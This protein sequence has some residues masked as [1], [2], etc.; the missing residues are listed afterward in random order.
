[1]Q[2]ASRPA[3][4]Q[5]RF[6]R[7]SKVPATH[8]PRLL[9]PV[10]PDALHRGSADRR[11][12]RHDGLRQ[13]LPAP[14]QRICPVIPPDLRRLAPV[15]P[16]RRHARAQGRRGQEPQFVGPHAG[17]RRLLGRTDGHRGQLAQ[18]YMPCKTARRIAKQ[19]LSL[20]PH[21]HGL[22]DRH[23]A[24]QGVRA[25]QPLVQHRGLRG[26]HRHGRHPPAQQPPLDERHHGGCRHRHPRHGV[27][28]LPGRPD[29][30]GEG[31][32]RHRQLC[33]LRPVP[34]AVVPGLLARHFRRGG[35]LYPPIRACGR[36]C[37][38]D[39]P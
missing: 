33:R 30:Q 20:G 22:Y 23:D 37:S 3:D 19:L 2:Y 28:L 9:D 10:L 39:R 21:R 4:R 35:H 34:Q 31:A 27:R 12:R 32:V 13:G 6:E 11:R 15:C 25:P 29:I 8:R 1:M 18:I 14:A 5:P 36:S 7:R 26:R 24:P 16:G 17:L 38:Q